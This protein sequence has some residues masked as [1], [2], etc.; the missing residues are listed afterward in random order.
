MDLQ[1]DREETRNTGP[2]QEKKCTGDHTQTFKNTGLLKLIAESDD[3]KIEEGYTEPPPSPA[4]MSSVQRISSTQSPNVIAD[5]VMSQLLA[6]EPKA[7]EECSTRNSTTPIIPRRA[8]VQRIRSRQP[9]SVIA[10]VVTTQ[11]LAEEPKN[12]KDDDCAVDAVPAFPSSPRASWD[13]SSGDPNLKQLLVAGTNKMN[14]QTPSKPAVRASVTRHLHSAQRQQLRH[15]EDEALVKIMRDRLERANKISGRARSIPSIEITDRFLLQQAN[16]TNQSVSAPS[17]TTDL[18][19]SD[20]SR[21]EHEVAAVAAN[22][23]DSSET[24][25]TIVAAEIVPSPNEWQTQIKE[26]VTEEV[27]REM[28]TIRDNVMATPVA[29]T[30]VVDEER[31]TESRREA[32][33]DITRSKSN[34][35]W[36]I[37][38]STLVIIGLVIG[39]VL[40]IDTGQVSQMP[41]IHI[42]NSSQCI[43]MNYLEVLNGT[44]DDVVLATLPQT[45]CYERIPYQ[46]KSKSCLSST[47]QP[48]GSGVSNLLAQAQLWYFPEADISIVNAGQMKMDLCQGNFTKAMAFAILPY[49][50]TAALLRLTGASL[51]RVLEQALDHISVEFTMGI[52]NGGGYP[53]GAG[54][55]YWVNMME[56]FPN[57]L[58]TVQVNPQLDGKW[59][60]IDK[61]RNYTIVISSYLANGGDGYTELAK[62]RHEDTNI[63]VR[64]IFMNYCQEEGKLADP[65]NS[66]YSTQDYIHDPQLFDAVYFQDN[67]NGS[68]K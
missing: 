32:T 34:I 15:E 46:G 62:V 49:D 33:I 22:P 36:V 43:L 41:D 18:R 64:D 3:E 51:V 31:H 21:N 11:L 59:I 48:L 8:S 17:L 38:I 9:P 68:H 16:E 20:A 2:S 14:Q 5:V 53:Y 57:R 28:D 29:A 56:S 37:C 25:V 50:N 27:R 1:Q 24:N 12:E 47:P 30:I 39:S 65:P 66:Q 23:F 63:L 44:Q 42:G 7:E 10:D 4:R 6:E 13:S 19:Y 35:V 45:I 26:A 40:R 58:T 54:I 55:R 52:G 60:S 61:Q 67:E